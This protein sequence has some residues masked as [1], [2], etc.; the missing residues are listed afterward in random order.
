MNNSDPDKPLLPTHSTPAQHVLQKADHRDKVVH[1]LEIIVLFAVVLFTIITLVRLQQII[2]QNQQSTLEARRINMARQ[3]EI[4]DYIK[5]I[6][7][8]KYDTPPEDLT[9]RTGTEAALNACAK[10]R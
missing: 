6:V 1:T 2:D 3:T 5:C 7:L 9:T 4:K 10:G 8:I